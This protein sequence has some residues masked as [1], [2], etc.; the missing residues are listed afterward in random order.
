MRRNVEAIC[1]KAFAL[2]YAV[3]N[4]FRGARSL[5]I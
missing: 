1:E 2:D 4:L 3:E 5:R